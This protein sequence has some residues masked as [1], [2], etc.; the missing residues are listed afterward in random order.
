MNTNLTCLLTEPNAS[1]IKAV[2]KIVL[3]DNTMLSLAMLCEMSFA[4][5]DPISYIH[6]PLAQI[7]ILRSVKSGKF[8]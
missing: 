5:G 8:P 4:L 7:K 6:I 1:Y 3:G 2:F